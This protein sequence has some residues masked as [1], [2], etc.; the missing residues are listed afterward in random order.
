MESHHPG[1]AYD[2]IKSVLKRAELQGRID[3]TESFL[4]LEGLNPSTGMKSILSYVAHIM[5]PNVGR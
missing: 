5:N 4:R 1:F 3:M 2:F